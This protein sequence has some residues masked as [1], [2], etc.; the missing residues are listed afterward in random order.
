MSSLST[1]ARRHRACL[2]ASTVFIPAVLTCILPANAQQSASPK[3]R[4]PG[5]VNGPAPPLQAVNPPHTK[6]PRRTAGAWVP[7]PSQ[8]ATPAQGTPPTTPP[9]QLVVSPTGIVGPISQTPSSVSVITSKK[10]IPRRSN[11]RATVPEAI[12][13]RAGSQRRSDRRPRRA[14]LRLHSR[15]QFQPYQGADRRH[16]RRRSKYSQRGIRFRPSVDRRYRADRSAARS[17]SRTLYGSDSIR[18]RYLH[19]REE[20][21]RARAGNGIDRNRLLRHLQPECRHQRFAERLQLR[22][23]YHASSRQR[24]AGDPVSASAAGPPG[25]RQQLRQHDLFDQARRRPQRVLVRQ[26]GRTLHRGDAALHGRQLQ[27]LSKRTQR[28]AKHARSPSVVHARRGRPVALRRP[29][30]ELLRRQLHK[31]LELRHRSRRSNSSLAP[32]EIG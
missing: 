18:R 27:C 25:E 29:H 28:R 3:L 5:T 17:S 12:A 1:A 32:P 11:I 30:Q 2:L 20:G 9:T 26:C 23:Q 16:R 31:Q 19:H 22:G 4:P 14:D 13:S 10:G 24:L 8:A 6:K 15:H 21:R 7:K